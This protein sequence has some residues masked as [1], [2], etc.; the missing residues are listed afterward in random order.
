MKLKTYKKDLQEA[1]KKVISEKKS[2]LPILTNFMLKAEDGKLT[3]YGTDLEVYTTYSIFADIE[4]EGSICV[5]AK[6]LAD[7]SKVLGKEEVSIYTE[8]ENL[9]ITLGKTKYSLSTFEADDYPLP[10]EFPSNATILISGKELLKGI[11]KT[12][13]AVSKDSSRFA[14]NGVCFSFN[15]NELEL[16]ATDGHRLAL[17][18]IQITGKGIEGK[19]IV[20]I[21]A[22]NELK[23]LVSDIEDVEIAVS[24]S[25]IFFKSH[26]YMMS[27]R[28][29]EGI[30][31][32][33]KQVIPNSYNI[34]VVLPKEELIGSIKRTTVAEED[35]NKPIKMVLTKNKLTIATASRISTDTYAE[36]EIDINYDGQEFE[37]G[38]NGK[39]IL[40]AVD[41]IDS[42]N[43]V[44]K[45]INKDSQTT[46]T[47][48]NQEEKY[49][50][51]VMPMTL[52]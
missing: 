8:G 2:A 1:L 12:I 32:D 10:E 7:I 30:F 43:I 40:E 11:S 3:I 47:P 27:A 6:K 41:K 36:D 9:K 18:N 22:L 45:F 44:V 31:P 42:D 26:N 38:F 37:I 39:Y 50:A 48:E 21:K 13:Y 23:K 17:Y 35:E 34:E 19:Y 20:P 16:V 24:E 46:F 52:G 33:Y 28:L 29:L 5:N 25:S 51:L 14:L 4:E 49:L 15:G